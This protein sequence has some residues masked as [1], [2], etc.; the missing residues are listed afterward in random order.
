MPTVPVSVTAP[1]CRSPWLQGR[2]AQR[3]ADGQNR[4]RFGLERPQDGGSFGAVSNINT[5]TNTQYHGML[6]SLERRLGNLTLSGN[7]TWSHCIGDF[8]DL[9]AAGPATDETITNPADAKFDH[10]N[11]DSDRRHVVNWTTVASMPKFANRTAR[12]LASGWRLS[13]VYRTSSGAPLTVISGQDHALVGT[14][15]QRASQILASPYGIQSGRPGTN[16]LNRNAFAVPAPGTFG[17]IGRNSI[18]GLKTWSFDL[19]LS[20]IFQLTENQ[21]IEV[22]AE[23]YNV[24]NSFR[25]LDPTTT[26]GSAGRLVSLGSGTFG[27]VREAMDP[28]ILQ[29]A[30]KYFF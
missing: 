26:I 30:M 12:M 3:R 19:S 4:R 16:Y 14:T 15:N 13:G 18:R 29:F 7:Y 1:P 25:P 17:N 24:T 5:D 2:R 10:G 23:A 6:L 8:A 28:R 20:R 11:C 22:R 21:R 27:V 9:N